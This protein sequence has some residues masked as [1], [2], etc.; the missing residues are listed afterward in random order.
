MKVTITKLKELDDALHPNNIP[1]GFSTTRDVNEVYFR[2]PEIGCRFNVGT[3]STSGVQEIISE[4]TFRTY[5]SIY[6][7]EVVE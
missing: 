2:E 6:K 3:F 5:S 7:W 1:E 4:N